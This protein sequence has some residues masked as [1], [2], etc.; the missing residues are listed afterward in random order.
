[1]DFESKSYDGDRKMSEDERK[2]G[3]LFDDVA[4]AIE[5]IKAGSIVIVVDD[6]DRENEG[7]LIMAAE[8]VTPEAINFMVTYGRGL[9][10]ASLEKEA[11]ERLHLEPMTTNN[12]AKLGT[13]FTVSVDA[14]EGTTTGISAFDRATTSSCAP[15]IQRPRSIWR[16]WRD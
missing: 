4:D 12:T 2:Q 13:R 5:E 3:I 8:K 7:D 16:V 14:V 6:E 10:C 9:V 11:I 1:L 15:G